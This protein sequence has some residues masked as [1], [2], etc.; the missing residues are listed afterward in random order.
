MKKIKAINMIGRHLNGESVYIYVYLNGQNVIY[1]GKGT[2]GD[3][4]R[5]AEDLKNHKGIDPSSVT[6]IHIID[7][8]YGEDQPIIEQ[9]W[10][11]YYGGILNLENRRREVSRKKYYQK[12]VE[13]NNKKQKTRKEIDKLEL[14]SVGG[15]K[16]VE[17]LKLSKRILNFIECDK[18]VAF[19]GNGGFGTFRFAFEVCENGYTEE[20]T[21]INTKY[22]KNERFTEMAKNNETSYYVENADFLEKDFGE[23]KYKTII[24]NPPWNKIG[25]EFIDKSISLLEPGGKLVCIIGD[26]QFSGKKYKNSKGTF[27]DLN[28]RGYFERIECFSGK[29]LKKIKDRDFFLQ[30]GK[31]VK[32]WV[33]FIWKKETNNKST[34]IVN[35]IGEEF[36][37]QLSG[38]EYFI[39]QK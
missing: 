13:Y 10:I 16:C 6:S 15:D 39:P 18:D 24:M 35:K 1:V 19:V 31:S 3:N 37:Y 27:K 5:R 9:Q 32:G 26:T 12:I 38:K 2:F 14:D 21:L 11:D 29:P 34:T 36:E 25:T 20:I 33:W 30:D 28:E 17:P 22:Q 7:A 23:R 8:C 4:F